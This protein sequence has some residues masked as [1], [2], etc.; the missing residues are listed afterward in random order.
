MLVYE[1][2]SVRAP[3]C[4]RDHFFQY[5]VSILKSP[6][7]NEKLCNFNERLRIYFEINDQ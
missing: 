1:C 4:I 3:D 2:L 5:N 6:E 7:V